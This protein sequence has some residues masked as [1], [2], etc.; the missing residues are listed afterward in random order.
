[1]KKGAGVLLFGVA[2]LGLLSV[3]LLLRKPEPVQAPPPAPSRTDSAAPVPP[4]VPIP[5]PTPLPR[6]RPREESG[7]PLIQRWR[8][9]IRLHNS[10]DVLDVQSEFL[11]KEAEVRL[12]LLALAKEDPEPRVRA[13]TVAVLGRLKSPP[14]EDY[15]LERA[16]DPHE[17]PRTSAL[18]ALEKIGTAACLPTVDRL[19]S[20]DPAESVRTAAAQAA[21][22]VRSR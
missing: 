10:K 14:P 8:A 17:Y 4:A 16:G 6:A 11:R 22:A 20:G 5:V 18:Q 21:K 2:G 12:T 13:F 7:D 9:A 19:A 1:M 15:F 3:A